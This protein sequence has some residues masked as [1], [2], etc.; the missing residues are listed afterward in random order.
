VLDEEAGVALRCGPPAPPDTE[1]RSAVARVPL[2]GCELGPLEDPGLGLAVAQVRLRSL[3]DVPAV[4]TCDVLVAGGGTAGA[5]AVVAAREAGAD[6]VILEQL[7]DLGGTQT[8]GL[9]SGYYHGYRGGFTAR[10]DECVTARGCVLHNGRLGNR[11]VAKMLNYL[12]DA[13][14]APGHTR[15]YPNAVVCGA[16]VEAGQV[17]GLLAADREGLFRVR[18]K[19]ALD[20]TGDGDAAVFCGASSTFGDPRSGSAQDYSQWSLGRG[21]WESL[22]ADLDVIDQRLLSE[23]QRGLRLAHRRGRWFDF[24]A[25]LTVREGRHIEGEHTLDLR[26]ILSGRPF[27]DT[28]AVACTDWDPHGIGTSWLSRLGF[29]PVHTEPIPVRI[30]LRCCIPRGLR[31][32]LVTAKAISATPDAACLCRMAPDVQNLGYATG[33]A[34]AAAAAGDGDPRHLDLPAL[35][36]RLRELGIVTDQLPVPWPAASDPAS[37]V[38]RLAAGDEMALREVALLDRTVALPLLEAA[39]Q[40]PG[41]D[42]LNLA[43]GLAWFGALADGGPLAAELRRLAALEVTPYEDAHPRKA[44]NPRAGIVDQPDD[45]WRINQLLVLI[46]LAGAA[47]AVPAVADLI[48]RTTAG[49]PPL[50]ALNAYIRARIDMQRVPHF[51]RLLSIAFCAERLGH[52]GLAQPLEGLLQQEFVGGWMRPAV[53]EAGSCY[54]SAL[55]EVLLAAAAARCGSRP[56]VLRLASFLDDVHGILV[57]FARNE[58]REITGQDA[59]WERAAWEA[60]LLSAPPLKPTP[61]PR[62]EPVF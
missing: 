2:S 57:R 54:Y 46:G 17:R 19:V 21:G 24:A 16:E 38:A 62:G 44:G 52:P 59:G 42:R 45:Y 33:L 18:A 22:S 20:A 31:G 13:V 32:L 37:A 34:A 5:N 6:T 47:E 26:D 28:L 39:L 35:T 1:L 7:H 15:W 53:D 43:K 29:L 61:L 48:Q 27:D 3:G 56:G 23:V 50:R 41:G 11:R 58:L 8:L 30:P 51:D 10:L 60:R 4:D 40:G 14:H 25:M 36:A 9:V 12:L 55:A 49:G